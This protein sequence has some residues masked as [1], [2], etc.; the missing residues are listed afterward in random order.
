MT[1][2]TIYFAPD[3]CARVSMIALEKTNHPYRAELVRFMAGQHRS[4]DFLALN[5][6]GRVPTLVVDG[7]PLTENV[8]ILRWLADRFPEA[9]LMPASTDPFERAVH[10]SD[11]AFCAATLH[12]IVTR[13][14]F[15]I[16]FAKQPE[17]LPGVFALAEE[18]MRR[19]LLPV[20][21]RLGVAKWWY[22]EDWS[23]VDAYVNWVWFRISGTAFA[24]ADF[25]NLQRHQDDLMLRPA[26]Q[27]A[28]A[29]HA[30]A[31]RILQGEG[32]AVPLPQMANDKAA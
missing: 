8:A 29:R 2:I 28:L 26:V 30:D 18:A 7:R 6:S 13:L 24:T 15:P 3:T 11:L 9:G 10:L 27:R 32:L 23:V 31:H 12:P 14:R 16:F 4:P 22:G 5:P 19:V 20:E 17:A 21:R 25:P 1:D